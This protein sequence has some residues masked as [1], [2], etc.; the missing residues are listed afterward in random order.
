MPV[1]DTTTETGRRMLMVHMD[2]DGFISRSE[3]PGNPIAGEMVRDRVVRRY[4][5]PMTIS[6]IEA[7]IAP[8][9]L[10][11]GLSALAEQVARDIFAAPHVAI[12]SHSYSYPFF[13]YKAS[14]PGSSGNYNLRIPG[15]RFDIHREVDGSIAYIE[16]R[17]APR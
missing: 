3:T 10:Y 7:E 15:Y 9:G 12:A 8:D 11:P 4:A 13:W 14:A 6:V 1:P 17:L 2:G 5:I 16:R